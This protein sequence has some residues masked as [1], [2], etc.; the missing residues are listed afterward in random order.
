MITAIS[1]RLGKEIQPYEVLA[2]FSGDRSILVG[3]FSTPIDEM[4]FSCLLGLTREQAEKEVDRQMQLA[5]PR[6][7]L[8]GMEFTK[9]FVEVEQLDCLKPYTVFCKEKGVEGGTIHIDVVMTL[10]AEAA[11]LAG[12]ENC[13]SEWS[14]G[15]HDYGLEEIHCLGVVEG[16][17]HI[18]HWEDDTD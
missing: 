18:I 17:V 8:F 2:H 11:Q 10:N 3:R 6:H 9:V 4:P 14:G 12:R 5:T 15:G 7:P 13:R 16:D 1:T